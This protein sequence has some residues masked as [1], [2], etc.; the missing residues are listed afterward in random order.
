[1]QLLGHKWTKL[2]QIVTTQNTTFNY[3]PVRSVFTGDK[4]TLGEAFLQIFRFSP[5]NIIPPVPPIHSSPTLYK[6]T[7]WQRRWIKHA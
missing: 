1:M 7:N 6:R 2:G 4:V 5:I 3:V